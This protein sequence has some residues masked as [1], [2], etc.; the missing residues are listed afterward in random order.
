MARLA[1]RGPSVARRQRL[2]GLPETGTRATGG[3]YGRNPAQQDLGARPLA[4]NLAHLAVHESTH[5]LMAKWERL[6]HSRHPGHTYSMTDAPPSP[7]INLCKVEGG[8]CV[9]CGRTLGEIAAWPSLDAALK[10][11]VLTMAKARL[12]GLPAG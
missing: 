9:G 1:R 3:W 7:C 4:A 10:A 6:S 2:C 11:S 5:R 12:R 8:V